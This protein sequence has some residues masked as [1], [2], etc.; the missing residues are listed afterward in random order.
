MSRHTQTAQEGNVIVMSLRGV[1]CPSQLH[2]YMISPYN[3]STAGNISGIHSMHVL[4]DASKEK[5]VFSVC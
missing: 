1:L 3:H 4:L 2:R 5:N